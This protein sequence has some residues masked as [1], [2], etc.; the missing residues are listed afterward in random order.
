MD[1]SHFKTRC[2]LAR[3][4]IIGE[5]PLFTMAT[6]APQPQGQRQVLEACGFDML[7]RA[8][9]PPFSLYSH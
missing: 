5:A 7:R 4:Q 1:P 6:A 2:L 3:Q 8:N 9:R